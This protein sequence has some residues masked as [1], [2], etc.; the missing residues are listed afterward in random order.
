MTEADTSANREDDLRDAASRLCTACGMCCNGVLFEIVRLQPQ[1]DMR[2][3]ERLGMEIYRKKKEPYFKQPCRF[4]EGCTCTI[5]A[6]RPTRCRHFECRQLKLL[7]AEEITESD[8]M[9]K[10][11]EVQTLVAKVHANLME[12]GDEAEQDSLDERTRRVLEHHPDAA[13]EED[14]RVLKLLLNREFRV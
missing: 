10:I 14:L 5:Y 8:A 13:L 2:G 9:A 12:L 7:A 4:L 1:D 11:T 6:Q 3:L